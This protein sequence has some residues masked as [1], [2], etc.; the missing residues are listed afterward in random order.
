MVRV[1]PASGIGW[2]HGNAGTRALE[3][4]YRHT[5]PAHSLMQGA[6]AAVARLALAVAPHARNVH[7]VCGPGNNG[8]DGLIAAVQLQQVGRRVVV[9]RVGGASTPPADA[10]WALAQAQLAG[11]RIQAFDGQAASVRAELT[12]DALL[13]LGI[14]RAPGGDLAVA[15]ACLNASETPVLAIDLPS[16]LH[17]D[18]GQAPG[19]A[20]RADHTLTLLTVKPGL[21]TGKGRDHSGQVWF[22]ALGTIPGAAGA[23]ARLVAERILQRAWPARAHASHKGRFGDLAVVGGARGMV[24]AAWLAARAGLAAGAG[25]VYVSPLDPDAELMLPCQLELMGRRSWWLSAADAIARTTVV[26][27]CGGGQ[28]VREALP[29]LL[30]RAPRLVLDADALNAVAAD[31][32][33]QRLLRSRAER[34]DSTVLTPHPLEA[35][36]LL[37]IAAAE[38]Q[39]DRLLSATNLASRYRCVVVLKGSG[40]VIASPD[41]LPSINLTGNGKLASAGTGDVLAGWIGGSWSAG[42]DA[43]QA[44]EASVWLHGL[45][46]DHMASTQGVQ[47]PLPAGDLITA[48]QAALEC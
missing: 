20:V 31:A 11:V 48:M 10:A 18:S 2:L 37:G 19:I 25:R 33:L 40:T 38:V 34:G 6:G 45:A 22:D 26:C 27:G 41:A 39:H 21:F 8:G 28:S 14:S 44:A 47:L 15:I 24:G 29:P 13:G 16:G 5:L 1:T 35:A 12:L 36:R 3:T 46:A 4:H 30:S 42:Q 17:A 43:T 32:T 9:S 23:S 7:V